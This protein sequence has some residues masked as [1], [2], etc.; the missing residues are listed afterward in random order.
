[1]CGWHPDGF[2]SFTRAQSVCR[3][4]FSKVYAQ[5]HKAFL[6]KI[7]LR[8]FCSTDN[9]H[10]QLLF[11]FGG[12]GER[13]PMRGPLEPRDT[14]R[15]ARTRHFCRSLGMDSEYALLHETDLSAFAKAIGSGSRCARTVAE[16][17]CEVGR[18]FIFAPFTAKVTLLT[19]SASK[20]CYQRRQFREFW[21]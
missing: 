19:L 2:N 14:S 6:V 7:E 10:S 15:P 20:Q 1:M 12:D 11:G 21:A 9:A 13:S 4:C 3:H 5:N 17:K 16:G 18:R 8:I